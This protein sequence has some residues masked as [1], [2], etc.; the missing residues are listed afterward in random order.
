MV[1][2]KM[3]PLHPDKGNGVSLTRPNSNSTALSSFEP[4]SEGDILKIIKSST[5]KSCGLDPIETNR[6]LLK[7]Y[8]PV[9][10]LSFISKLIENVMAKQLNNYI[11]S[12]GLSN[13]NQSAYRRLHSTE[14]ALLKIQNDI[15]ASMDSGKAV[16]LTLLDLSAAFDTIDHDILFNSLRDWFGVDGTVLRWIKS[17]L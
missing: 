9:S 15:A 3:A 17:Y 16:A 11:D 5:T 7:N 8:R 13:V 2:R 4:V 10:N 1:M 6:N 12:E 14:S